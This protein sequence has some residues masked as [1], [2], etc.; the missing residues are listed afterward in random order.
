MACIEHKW[1]NYGPGAIYSPLRILIQPANLEEI[2]VRDEIGFKD[3][4]VGGGRKKN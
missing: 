1:E 2:I 4:D 3:T